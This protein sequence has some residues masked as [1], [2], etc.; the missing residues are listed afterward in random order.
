M[1]IKKFYYGSDEE[2]TDQ[3]VLELLKMYLGGNLSEEQVEEVNQITRYPWSIMIGNDKD[4]EIFI[5][6]KISDIDFLHEKDNPRPIDSRTLF[7]FS[8]IKELGKKYNGNGKVISNLSPPKCSSRPREI[9]KWR[10]FN[11]STKVESDIER[12]PG[13]KI[14]KIALDKYYESMKNF[15][16][17]EHEIIYKF[18]FGTLRCGIIVPIDQNLDNSVLLYPQIWAKK[19]TSS[20]EGVLKDLKIIK[21]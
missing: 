1:D 10:E 4:K 6:E 16:E 17:I 9:K 11:E 7:S 21:K 15:G 2:P 12:F 18:D 14:K 5:T 19:Y 20:F 8:Y 13:E 3:E